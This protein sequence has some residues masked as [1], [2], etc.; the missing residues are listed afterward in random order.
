LAERY[1]ADFIDNILTNDA[2]VLALVP[3]VDIS[4][5]VLV[6]QS[7]R[8]QETINYYRPGTFSGGVSWFEVRW[9]I[10]CRSQ[11]YTG[12]RDIATAASDALNRVNSTV[13]GKYYHAVCDILPTLPPVDK[14]DV[15]NT[16]VEVLI[17][18]R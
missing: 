4:E 15:Y 12:S 17:R 9:S 3:A 7:N 13:N 5:N 16:P 10:N 14:A 2:T 1:G 6:S 18:R 8:T 11:T